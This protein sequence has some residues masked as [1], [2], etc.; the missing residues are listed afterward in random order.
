MPLIRSLTLAA[1]CLAATG[2]LAQTKSPNSPSAAAAG[3]NI[4]SCE[5]L[6]RKSWPVWDRSGQRLRSTTSL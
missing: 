5:A 2:A 6:R 4:R 1:A 3:S